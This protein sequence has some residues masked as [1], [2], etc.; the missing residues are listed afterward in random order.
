MEVDAWMNPEKDV[1]DVKNSICDSKDLLLFKAVST[2]KYNNRE[3]LTIKASLSKKQYYSRLSKFIKTSLIEGNRGHYSLTSLGV[4]VRESLKILELAF[5]N[6]TRLKSIDKTAESPA[7]RMK[8]IETLVDDQ[9]LKSLMIQGYSS[10]EGKN[11]AKKRHFY[12]KKIAHSKNNIILIEA[13]RDTLL[14]F[15][16]ILNK[17]GFNVKGFVD[18]YEA[19][20]HFVQSGNNYDLVICNIHLPRLN[21]FELCQKMNKIDENLK[22]I[23]VTHNGG[24]EEIASIIKRDINLIAVL[25]KPI[26]EA[27]LIMSMHNSEVLKS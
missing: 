12:N 27:D 25:K 17:N 2:D 16:T 24:V 5:Y 22:V 14:T 4:L 3:L 13:D 7:E 6:E 8:L 18:P 20:N 11:V 1:L 21:G 19:L 10:L 23:I 9:M 26:R 15:T